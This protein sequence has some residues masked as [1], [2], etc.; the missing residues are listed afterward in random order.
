[1]L[2]LISLVM[3]GYSYFLIK[4]TIPH[5]PQR[6]PTHFNAAGIPNGWG[7]ANTLWVLLGAQALTWAIFLTVP[8]IGQLSPGAVHLGAR[9]LTDFPRAQ[10][11]RVLSMLDD[12]AGYMSMVM[13]LFFVFVLRRIIQAATQPIPHLH[14]FWP[15][16]LLMAGMFAITL[17]YLEQFR[18]AAGREARE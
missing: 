12:M 14:M 2:K 9:R 13:N 6:I 3:V 4:T 10:R 7:S 1:M 11:Q 8:Y 17:Y 15:L 18:R 16:A 5:L